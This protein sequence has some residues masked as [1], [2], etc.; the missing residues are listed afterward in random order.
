M[1]VRRDH[2]LRG[3][4]RLQ[5]LRKKA[6][7]HVLLF[8]NV[9]FRAACSLLDRPQPVLWAAFGDT[10][11]SPYTQAKL[12][13]DSQQSPQLGLPQ[14]AHGLD[15]AKYFLHQTSLLLAAAELRMPAFALAQPVL[16][17]LRGLELGDQRH[18]CQS[19]HPHNALLILISLVSRHQDLPLSRRHLRQLGQ[20]CV[21]LRSPSR[22][23]HARFHD[24]SVAVFRNHMPQITRSRWSLRAFTV[25]PGLRI[26][27]AFMRIPQ[28]FPP[29]N[30]TA[31]LRRIFLRY[32]TLPTRPGFQQ[33]PIHREVLVVQQTRRLRLPA[34]LLEKLLRHLASQQPVSV[35]GE[36]RYIP[37]PAV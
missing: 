27:C 18:D 35:L 13:V 1:L 30:A 20:G 15:P 37:Y 32:E 36:H 12:P 4:A 14:S 26:A 31:S 28:Q 17:V 33:R 11:P 5:S 6:L 24:Q 25:Q 9:V 22:F 3:G 2:A 34:Y 19:P 10:P 21:Q 16:P 23:G 8:W 29:T 7:F